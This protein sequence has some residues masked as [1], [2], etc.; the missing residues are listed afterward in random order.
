MIEGH[1]VWDDLFFANFY[2]VRSGSKLP[3]AKY[4]RLEYSY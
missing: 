1:S 3:F 4:A 2:L